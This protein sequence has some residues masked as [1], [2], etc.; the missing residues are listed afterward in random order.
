M[1]RLGFWQRFTYMPEYDI[2]AHKI[3]QVYLARAV[4][5]LG[6]P[7]ERGHRAIWMPVQTALETLDV[8]G[9]RAFLARAIG[10]GR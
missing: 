4:R 2:W 7:S 8:A 5:R 10:Q 6:P 1:R 9:D 3:C